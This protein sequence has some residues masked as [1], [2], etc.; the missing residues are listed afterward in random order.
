MSAKRGLIKDVGDSCELSNKYQKVSKLINANNQVIMPGYINAHHHF[1]ST[2]ARGLGKADP[3]KNFTEI[4]K[5]LWWRLD[6]TLNLDD[7]F[8]SAMIPLIDCIKKGCTT[9][10]DHHASPFNIMESLNKIK[11]A[12]EIAGIR[13]CLCYELSDRDGVEKAEQGL[14][15]NYNF[16]KQCK[17]ENNPFISALFGAHAQ[18]TVGDESM[19]KAVEMAKELGVGLHIHTAED[20]SDVDACLKDHNLRVVERLNKMGALGPTT[21]TPHCIHINEDEMKIL[22]ETGTNV[23]HNPQSNMNNAVG[24]ADVLKMLEMGIDVGMGSD[25]MTS[26]M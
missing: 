23:V 11:E 26:D 20:I 1:Y 21:I 19:K 3:S 14:K 8:Y 13:A 25:G 16:I 22:K 4:L 6:K 12:V 9:V 5:N 18:F 2:F 15:E 7:V 17:N 10:I 24:T